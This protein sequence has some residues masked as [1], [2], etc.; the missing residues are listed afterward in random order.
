MHSIIEKEPRLFHL[1]EAVALGVLIL[2]GLIIRL[3]DIVAWRSNPEAAFLGQEPLIANGDGYHYLRFAQDLLQQRYEPID[4]LRTIPDNPTRP[5]PPPLL[6]VL[7]AA[8]VRLTPFSLSWVAVVLPSL[9][10]VLLAI[11]LYGIG[12]LLA[13]RIMGLASV[14]MGLASNSF[15]AKSSLG[16]YDTDCLI[17]FFTLMA[18]FCLLLF[19]REKGKKRYGFLGLGGVVCL[20]FLWWWDQAPS[21][22]IALFFMPLAVAL[23][24]F[25]RPPAREAKQF[26]L[27][28]L[29]ILGL[30]FLWQGIQFPSKL[31]SQFHTFYEYLVAPARGAFPAIAGVISEQNNLPAADI[32]A[33]STG[34]L[35]A[36]V[37]SGAGLLLLA[38]KRPRETLLLIAPLILAGLTFVAERFMIFLAPVV[39]LGFGF[40]LSELYN[41]ISFRSLKYILIPSLIIYILWTSYQGGASFASPFPPATIAGMDAVREM[42]AEDAA[43]WTWC[44][45]GYPLMLRSGRATICDGQAHDGELSVYNAI[46]LATS[47]PRLAANFIRFYIS[48]GGAGIRKIYAALGNDPARGLVLLKEI[49]AAGPQ[50]AVPILREAELLTAEKTLEEWLRYF[51]PSSTRPVYLFLDWGTMQV[52]YWIESLG[53]WDGRKQGGDIPLPSKLFNRIILKGLSLSNSSGTMEADLV[54]GQLQLDG[55]ETVPLSQ[56]QVRGAG[57]IR[58]Y[59]YG[60]RPVQSGDAKG[61][62]ILDIFEEPGFALLMSKES[63]GRLFNRLF[64]L[65]APV[66]PE[67]FRP[68]LLRSPNY[69]LWEV[70]GDRFG[71]SSDAGS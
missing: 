5:W 41:L 20:F 64:W 50:E 9:L 58:R 57:G 45:N 40:M 48:H 36:F 62:Y 43:I 29:A 23:L 6:S 66:E 21:V 37:F 11:P 69:Q 63:W 56:A 10:G 22:V 53:T 52:S 16:E 68:I 71:E 33:R 31:L 27:A 1:L 70:G 15:V 12:R 49:L 44:D 61:E 2:W 18:P 42:T 39:A 32:I 13:G 7:T 47:N 24:F 3:D 65:G 35:A 19:V 54:R 60:N 30:V 34:S 26:L 67:Y 55:R 25:Y 14:A 8:I 38:R 59:E 51:F 4:E 28:T 17:P 46:P